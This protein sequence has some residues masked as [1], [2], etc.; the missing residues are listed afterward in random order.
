MA[1]GRAA[2]GWVAAMLVAVPGAAAASEWQTISTGQITVKTRTISG[3]VKEIWAEGTM[4]ASAFDIQEAILDAE[5]YPRFMPYVKEA[6]YVGGSAEGGRYV[7]TRLDLPF[8][9]AR[10]YVL[11][12]T[13]ESRVDGNGQGTFVNRWKATPGRVRERPQVTRIKT[14]EGSWEVKSTE[15]GKAYVVYRAVVDPGG[16]VPGFALDAANRKGVS[17]TW[18]AVENES[19]RRGT[20]RIARKDD[21]RKSPG[22]TPGA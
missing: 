17:D 4:A 3:S 16:W 7:Y 1:T 5:S 14:C 15:D 9:N 8:L 22:T 6:R 18:S 11:L 2:A 19:V 20:A 12:V 21:E 10:D 13:V